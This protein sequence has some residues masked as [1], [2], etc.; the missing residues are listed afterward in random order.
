M[1]LR[2]DVVD[3][4][5]DPR[6][7][8]VAV[9]MMIETEASP[10]FNPTFSRSNLAGPVLPRLARLVCEHNTVKALKILLRNSL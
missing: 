3:E 4:D 7:L 2:G 1:S 10:L 6:C 9:S 5:L 8:S